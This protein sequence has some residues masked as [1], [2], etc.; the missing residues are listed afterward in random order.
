[1]DHSPFPFIFLQ[2]ITA[3]NNVKKKDPTFLLQI[4]SG[5][6]LP[7]DKTDRLL[8][9]LDHGTKD[10]NFDVDWGTE[11]DSR[12]LSGIYEHGLGNWEEVKVGYFYK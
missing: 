12:L 10:A 9:T 3:S 4:F 8:W 11:E 5:K 6:I 7:D 1:M 2:M